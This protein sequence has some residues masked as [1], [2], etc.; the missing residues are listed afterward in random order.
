ML[1]WAIV[2]ALLDTCLGLE[3]STNVIPLVFLD[4]PCALA[5][6]PFGRSRSQTT[7]SPTS[8]LAP[9]ILRPCQVTCVQGETGSGKS[10]QVPQYLLECFD[11]AQASCGRVDLESK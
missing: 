6:K 11:D 2:Q 5:P 9:T 8:I 3:A 7:K 1:H 10:T 4:S